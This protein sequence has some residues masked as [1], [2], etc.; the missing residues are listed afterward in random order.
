MIAP[1]SLHHVMSSGLE[2]GQIA[3]DGEDGESVLAR[4]GVSTSG[5]AKAIARVDRREVH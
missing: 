2:R 1:D 3:A 5:I 4:L